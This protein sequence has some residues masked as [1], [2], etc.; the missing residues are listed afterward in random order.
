[1]NENVPGEPIIVVDNVFKTFPGGV[2]ALSDFSI[3]VRRKELVDRSIGLENHFPENAEWAE[4]QQGQSPYSP[5]TGQA[6]RQ[7][8]VKR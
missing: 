5:L 3:R 4:S 7:E 6:N 2:C 8:F 1:V